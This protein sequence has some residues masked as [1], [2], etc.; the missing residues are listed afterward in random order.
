MRF[1][2]RTKQL[3]LAAMTAA[4]VL[5]RKIE[6]NSVMP[7]DGKG[8]AV[9]G[10]PVSFALMALSA[11]AVIVSVIFAGNAKKVDLSRFVKCG[12]AFLG[13]ALIAGGAVLYAAAS[14]GEGGIIAIIFSVFALLCAAAI[15]MMSKNAG[16]NSPVTRAMSVCPAAFGCLW[17]LVTYRTFATEPQIIKFAYD[18]LAQAAAAMSFYYISGFY[19]K[20]TDSKMA[21]ICAFLGIFFSGAAIGSA[22]EMWQF[23]IYLGYVLAIEAFL[24]FMYDCDEE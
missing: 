18:C 13:A 12:G 14:I 11:A 17:L 10:S 21:E 1:N 7:I 9:E 5:L 6:F 24:L 16:E 8:L 20:K 23:L 15:F 2:S 19:F 4:A 22:G 3:V